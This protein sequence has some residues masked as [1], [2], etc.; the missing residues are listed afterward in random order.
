M[1]SMPKIP[2]EQRSFAD[3]SAAGA[4]DEG[5]NDRRDRATGVDTGQ[6]GDAGVNADQQGRFGNLN[7]NLTAIRNVQDR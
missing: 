5:L 2:K 3:Q 6:P 4:E 7:Q 1:S